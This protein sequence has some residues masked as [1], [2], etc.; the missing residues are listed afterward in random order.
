LNTVSKK[1]L[2]HLENIPVVLETGAARKA[3]RADRTGMP[4]EEMKALLERTRRLIAPQGWYRVVYV[5]TRGKDSVEAGGVRFQSGLLNRNLADAERIFP[6]VLTI[7]KT[8]E[9][10]AAG[11]RDDLLLQYHLETLGDLTLRLAMRGLEEHVRESFGIE[12]LS[13]MSPGSLPDWPIEEQRPLFA[14]LGAGGPGSGPGVSLTDSLLM[15]PRK[16]LS[17]I[18]F[19]TEHTFIACRLC[20]RPHCPSRIGDAPR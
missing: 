18:L 7:G 15:L 6:Y 8:L 19:P 11:V 20:P 9:V 10:E 2:H 13:S 3:L 16:S 17:G 12:K 1:D 4:P 14:L 5:E